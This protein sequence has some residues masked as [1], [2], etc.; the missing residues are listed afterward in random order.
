MKRGFR[1]A[2]VEIH[3]A[4]ERVGGAGEVACALLR[5]AKKNSWARLRWKKFDGFFQRRDG[6]GVVSGVECVLI[7]H[8]P[9]DKEGK[10]AGNSSSATELPTSKSSA[11]RSWA[12]SVVEFAASARAC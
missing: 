3:S 7:G 6:I 5:Y 12:I 9:R 2:R 1:V 11:L 10:L 8:D 4:F